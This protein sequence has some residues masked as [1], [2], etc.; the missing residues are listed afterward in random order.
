MF[1]QI[2][3]ILVNT[4]GLAFMLVFLF[5]VFIF[6]RA[7]ESF[8]KLTQ[9]IK[10]AWKKDKEDSYTRDEMIRNI[11]YFR[12]HNKPKSVIYWQSEL[13]RKFPNE[14]FNG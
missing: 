14:P 11:Y 8:T 2:M 9:V 6:W 5:V 12:N 13:M 10:T 4:L 1:D 3:T 7:R